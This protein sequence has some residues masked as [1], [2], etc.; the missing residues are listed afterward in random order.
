MRYSQRHNFPTFA[1]TAAQQRR[2]LAAL[3]LLLLALLL[4]FVGLMHLTG[5]Y[6]VGGL[7]LGE[8]PD[9]W[10]GRGELRPLTADKA[11]TF[12]IRARWPDDEGRRMTCHHVRR[13]S[14]VI[15]PI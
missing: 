13:S 3:V 2:L 4:I 6:E 5:G 9:D 15:R 7:V 12:Q 14:F 1:P 8:H 11:N 10:F